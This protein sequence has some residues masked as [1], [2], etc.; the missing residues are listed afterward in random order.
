MEISIVTYVFFLLI[1]FQIKHFVADYLLQTE[2]MLGKFKLK[3]WVRPLAEHAFVHAACTCIIGLVAMG[4][5]PIPNWAACVYA[6]FIAVIDFGIHFIVDRI[7]AS[8]NLLGRWTP[9]E[10][11]FWLSLG[12]DQMAHHLTHYLIILIIIYNVT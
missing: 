5:T 11:P 6:G 2:Y 10:R 3:G 8:P 7:K 9:A 12:A 4:I 1:A